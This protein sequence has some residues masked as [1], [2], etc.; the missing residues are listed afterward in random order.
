MNI[1]ETYEK[2]ANKTLTTEDLYT[3][4]EAKNECKLENNTEYSYLFDLLII[5]KD[6]ND[7]FLDNALEMAINDLDSLDGAL[8]H[9]I[10]LSF[11]DRIIY[12]C[13]AK[14]NYRSAYRYANRKKD[15][16][17]LNDNEQINRWYLE[18]SY[19]YSELG[20]KDKALLNL[21]AILSNFPDEETKSLVLSNLTKLYIDQNM[22]E[23]AKQSLNDC[24]RVTFS[25]NDEE[26]IIYCNYLNAKLL[27]L[28]KKYSFAH[29]VF[30]DLFKG[31]KI[32]SENY[33]AI[34]NEYV[35]LLILEKD[36]KEALAFYQRYT[37]DYEG[38][39]DIFLKKDYLKNLLMINILNNKVLSAAAINELTTLLKEI[40][41]IEEKITKENSDTLLDA[42]EDDKSYEVMGTLST[43]L[44][45]VEKV[46]IMV[47]RALASDDERTMIMDLSKTLEK[48]IGA[49]EIVYAIFNRQH[50]GVIPELFLKNNI[51][52]TYN[53]KKQRLYER[54]YDYNEILNT[55]F[56]LLINN[57]EE[58]IIDFTNTTVLIKD[59][60]SKKSYLD[61]DVKY[62]VA[63]P[64]FYNNEMFAAMVFTSKIENITTIDSVLSLKI[65][66]KSIEEKFVNIFLKEALKAQKRI[67]EVAISENE[68]SI[69]YYQSESEKMVLSNIVTSSLSLATKYISR[70]NYEK[71]VAIDD[72]EAYQKFK[73]S[74][75]VGEKYC[76]YYHLES[77]DKKIFVEEK[78]SPYFN[79]EGVCK[80]YVGT[81]T[82]IDEIERAAYY[83]KEKDFYQSIEKIKEE[84]VNNHE[85][86]FSIIK[87]MIK[88]LSLFSI[89]KKN[90]IIEKVYDSIVKNFS[91]KPYIM[92]D[93]SIYLLVEV[94]E[95]R[96][97]EKISKK[98]LSC[99]NKRLKLKDED[100]SLKIDILIVRYPVN[101]NNIDELISYLKME[102]ISNES[103]V[104]FDNELYK[105]YLLQ[106]TYL[107]CVDNALQENNYDILYEEMNIDKSYYITLNIKGINYKEDFKKY[108]PYDKLIEFE[109]VSFLRFINSA[110][111]RL[112]S[113]IYF[114]ITADTLNKLMNCGYFDERND[115][116]YKHIVFILTSF[117]NGTEETIASLKELSIRCFM[118]SSALENVSLNTID[119][120]DICGVMLENDSLTIIN[121]IIKL[122]NYNILIKD[123]FLT[124]RVFRNI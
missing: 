75:S 15:F 86:S 12:L 116:T 28:E 103:I 60:I 105:K 63:I 24:M 56:E 95:A 23:E 90:Q 53:Y 30:K 6:I 68:S 33:I 123:K 122:K 50:F 121:D 35:S 117:T 81:L 79:N 20:Q 88:N 106:R 64:L 14:K 69:F 99:F 59:L 4:S 107:S 111:L 110:K 120:M 112:D 96:S 70:K 72:F 11:L 32:L 97:L 124:G 84:K 93:E 74:T 83:F 46:I 22:I 80:F 89:E 16:L 115:K 66:S 49:D 82:L 17:N 119:K 113:D 108:L 77:N 67:T 40:N 71:M 42:L 76:V 52:E 102:T 87:I 27:V 18:M 48:E 104:I 37:I 38:C 1:K 101:T 21:K 98:I 92:N 78:A 57:C 9:N 47:T 5:D 34:G 65:S 118:K 85:Y 44:N 31:M 73:T 94:S 62:L 45:K 3:I 114:E 100:V 8:Y 61:L 7:N 39:H 19:I 91:Y 41:T 55:V 25:I 109:E 10:Y 58:T 26:G 29:S 54:N 36:Y 43:T 13:I 2:L 51:I